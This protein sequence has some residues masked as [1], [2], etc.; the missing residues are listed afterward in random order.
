M[1]NDSDG[2]TCTARSNKGL[3]RCKGSTT[4]FPTT[5]GLQKRTTAGKLMSGKSATSTRWGDGSSLSPARSPR[6]G[7]SR[8]SVRP[9][10]FPLLPSQYS[11]PRRS[12]WG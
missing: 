2:L 5:V 12:T 7:T 11:P 6:D 10:T 3:R 9:R 1:Q 4:W 8:E